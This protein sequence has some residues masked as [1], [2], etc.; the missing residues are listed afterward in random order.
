VAWNDGASSLLGRVAD[1]IDL[2]IPDREMRGEH[3]KTLTRMGIR[4]RNILIKIGQEPL[5]K[6]LADLLHRLAEREHGKTNKPERQ[7]PNSSE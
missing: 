1:N 4:I 3:A 2:R 5:P 6:R 7:N